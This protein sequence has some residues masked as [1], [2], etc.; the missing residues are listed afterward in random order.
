MAERET[1]LEVFIKQQVARQEAGQ[2]ISQADQAIADAG[3]V[4][5]PKISRAER[6]ARLA[7]VLE[8]GSVNPR[9]E[10]KL[11]PHLW[12]EW[13]AADPNEIM[14]MEALG[15]RIDTEFA[16]SRALHTKGERGSLVGDVIFM[17]TERENYELIQEVYR[18]QYE[19]LNHPKRQSDG[20]T[21]QREEKEVAE[22]LKRQGLVPI[23]ASDQHEARKAE[24]EAVLNA[25]EPAVP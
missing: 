23:N 10:V 20:S 2:T 6:K 25:Q 16:P 22:S 14:R 4:A 24:I 13:I 21:T 18:D 11:P 15:Y 9:L 19:R 3:T 8:R 7:M 17:T 12:G 1:E 5:T